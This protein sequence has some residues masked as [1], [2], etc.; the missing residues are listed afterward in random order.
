MNV[1]P[2]RMMLANKI[3][4]TPYLT[5]YVEFV[6]MAHISS[7]QLLSSKHN[8]C[9][10]TAVRSGNCIFK[11]HF[12]STGAHNH[13]PLRKSAYWTMLDR[14]CSPAKQ[15]LSKV[16]AMLSSPYDYAP[17][18]APFYRSRNH[19]TYILSMVPREYSIWRGLWSCVL[20]TR[21]RWARHLCVVH[22]VRL[23]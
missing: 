8:Y 1:T 16:D 4:T 5:K 11:N 10:A 14:D 15:Y 21:G 22:V 19:S 2:S 23:E 12:P 17:P 20:G 7:Y 13:Q 3:N 6:N 18:G 9:H